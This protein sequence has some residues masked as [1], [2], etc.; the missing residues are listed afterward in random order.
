MS[1]RQSSK[2]CKVA[3]L[4]PLRAVKGSHGGFVLTE[5][6]IQGVAA[7]AEN[8]GAPVTSF[9]MLSNKKT[10]DMDHAEFAPD[11]PQTPIAPRPED[12]RE[13]AHHLK[14][15]D[16]V[17]AFL[18]SEERPLLDICHEIGV[19]LVLSAEFSPRTE[20]Q[21]IEFDT[22]NVILR[23]RRKLWLRNA[24]RIRRE[25]VRA[26]AGLQCSG[27]PVF[28]AYADLSP[29]PLLFFD[30]RV[31]EQDVI[32]PAE[33]D[34]KMAALHQGAP[35]RLAFGGRFVPMKGVQY[36]PGFAR[37][38]REKG[39]PFSLDIY[40]TGPLEA[41][42][43]RKIDRELLSDLVQLKGALPFHS[44]W[45]PALKRDVDLFIC[46][47]PQGDPSS[48]YPEVMSCGVPIAGFANEAFEGIRDASGSGW[49]VPIKNVD[50]LASTVAGLHV[51]R[52]SLAAHAQKARKFA[53][54]HTFE[55]TMRRR[56]DHLRS[57]SRVQ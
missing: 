34:R 4:P 41:D 36:L 25:M 1:A 46:P 22:R 40:G 33:M 38:L 45:I 27:R 3:I 39:I 21:I 12:P 18:S 32:T 26:T 9:V 29:D 56:S 37:K 44:G 17:F 5:K 51:D 49:S 50:T 10:T 43:L 19:P 30:N 6:Y 14:E 48:T 52:A 2:P 7:Y 53:M 24:T 11:D 55:N 47:H 54:E 31:R 57:L 23:L 13:L 15:A 35:L 42:I 16:V 20:H 8:L 28:D